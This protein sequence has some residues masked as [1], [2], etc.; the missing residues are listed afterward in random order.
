MEE[1]FLFP[2]PQPLK[3]YVHCGLWFSNITWELAGNA[4]R[5]LGL[6]LGLWNQNLY[7]SWVHPCLKSTGLKPPTTALPLV[8]VGFQQAW[9]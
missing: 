7:D 6:T 8:K 1:H 2:G 3:A 5:I 9:I 4:G